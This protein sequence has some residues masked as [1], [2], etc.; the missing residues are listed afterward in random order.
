MDESR[1]IT[2]RL[3]K[4]IEKTSLK[5]PFTSVAEDIGVNEKTVRNIFQ[6]YVARLEQKQAIKTP[7]WLGIDEVHLLRNY[8]CVITDVENKTVI[9]LLRNR[10]QDTVIRNLSQFPNREHIKYVAMDMW[11]PYRR[12]VHT[13]IP[14]AT[15]II[16]KFHVVKM[17]NEALEKIRKANRENIT[18]KERRQLKKD[19]YVLLTRKSELNDFDDQLKLQIWMDNSPLLGKGYELKEKFFDIYKAKSVDE[20]YNLY[21]SWITEIPKE[22]I[23]YFEPLI[24]AM[25][26]WEAEIFNYFDT[27]TTNAYTESLNNLIKVTNKIGRGYSFEALRAKI[28]FT[29]GSKTKKKKKFK[30]VNA[31]FGKMLDQPLHLQP[32]AYQW[33][34]EEV[35]GADIFTLAKAME[36]GSF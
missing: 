9:D 27:P 34:Y 12:A 28:L 26:N 33:V 30:D 15:I 5:K 23:P 3:I 16:D 31:S 6:Y 19:R 10:N 1:S 32:L 11:N 14:G 24:K 18:A 4:W 21:Q 7:K 13:V 8:R 29:E 22:L 25:T 36:E 35:Y 20:A 2:R 17:A